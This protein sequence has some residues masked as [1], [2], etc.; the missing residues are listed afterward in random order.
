VIA[1]AVTGPRRIGAIHLWNAFDGKPLAPIGGPPPAPFGAVPLSPSWKDI[2]G[3]AFSP[4]GDVIAAVG[5]NKSVKLW[6]VSSGQLAGTLDSP[7]TC[8]AFSPD[9]TYLAAGCTREIHVW[10]SDAAR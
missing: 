8:L 6:E 7:A 10:R 2:T 3:F 9:G 5:D 1:A 4:A